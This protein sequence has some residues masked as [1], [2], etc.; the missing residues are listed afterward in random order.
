MKQGWPSVKKILL[1]TTIEYAEDDWSIERFSILADLLSANEEQP[2]KKSFHVTA[3][4]RENLG[5]GDD[6]VLRK[7]DETDFDQILAFSA[8]MWVEVWVRRTAP[9]S[10]VFGNA[11][12]Q[13]SLRARS[14]GPGYLVLQPWWNWSSESFSLQESRDRFGKA[15]RGRQRDA[16]HL[17][18][19][20]PFRQEW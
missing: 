9:R 14:P 17:V 15:P 7:L 18:A 12:A 4:N 1:Q 16:D 3:R 13:S 20:L 2:G 5:S 6:R 10:V 8:S 19:Q 11:A